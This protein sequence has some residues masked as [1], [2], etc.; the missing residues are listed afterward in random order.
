MDGWSFLREKNRDPRLQSIPVIVF[1]GQSETERQITSEHA[2]F[3]KK[4]VSLE[5]LTA[6][7]RDVAA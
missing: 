7:I 2:Y 5:Q 1:S 4:P 6:V 3:L